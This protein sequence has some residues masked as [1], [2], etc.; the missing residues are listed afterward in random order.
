[1]KISILGARGSVPTNGKDMIEFGGSTSCVL[2]ETDD[3]A[4][5]LDA[6][7]GILHSPDVGKK[8]ISIL[9]T[10][11]HFDHIMGLPFFPYNGEKGRKINI[12]GKRRDNLSVRDQIGLLICPPLWPC[13]LAEYK[14]DYDIHDTDFPFEIGDVT[15]DVM[16]SEHPGGSLIYR[17]SDKDK[18]LVYATDYEYSEEKGRE[19]TEFAKDADLLLIDGQYTE[20]EIAT[21]K[22]FG[23]STVETGQI[24]IRESGVKQARFVHH[25]PRHKD[26]MLKKMEKVVKSDKVAFAREG[27]VIVL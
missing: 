11:P 13:T 8:P 20:E 7:T 18:I 21:R 1:M 24:I 16:E 22:G 2:V 9:I 26:E 14:A 5:F 10:H 19:L 6:G 15:V 4:I 23:H 17:I 25:D 12:Y 3:Q 27:E